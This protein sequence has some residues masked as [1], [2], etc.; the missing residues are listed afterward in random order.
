M[1][2]FNRIF[3]VNSPIEMLLS[4]LTLIFEVL[5]LFHLFVDKMLMDRDTPVRNGLDC[6]ICVLL[7]W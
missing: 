1:N 7:G 3:G 6:I 5:L 2:F 4:F